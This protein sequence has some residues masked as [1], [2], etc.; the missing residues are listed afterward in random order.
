MIT[1]TSKKFFENNINY[2]HF[3]KKLVEVKNNFNREKNNEYFIKGEIHKLEEYL[4]K[5]NEQKI[6]LNW[7][8]SNGGNHN[9]KYSED[10]ILN[11]DNY[12]NLKMIWKFKPKKFKIED[13]KYNVEVNP[14][15][16]IINYL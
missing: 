5:K 7:T 8:R 4:V 6:N 13:W 10:I 15:F 11:L 12:K 1:Q 14:I 2:I 16:L 9:L 3:P